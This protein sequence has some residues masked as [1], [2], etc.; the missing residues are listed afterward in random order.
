MSL[1][2]Y[3]KE[4]LSSEAEIE[5]MAG[6]LPP[7]LR[8]HPGAAGFVKL[9]HETTIRHRGDLRRRL[10]AGFAGEEER[11]DA[12]GTGSAGR[13]LG[14]LRALY[15]QVSQV[16]L[17]YAILHAV[18]HRYF[19]GPQEGTTAELAENH[20]K[21]YAEVVRLMNNAI[22]DVAVWELGRQGSECRCQ[23][24]ACGLGICLCS[25]HGTNTV[26]DV[27]RE[28]ASIPAARGTSGMGVR[29][30][31][32]GSPA[33]VAKIRSGDSVVSVDDQVI[34]DEG[35]E[36]IRKMQQKIDGH[37]PGDAIRLGVRRAKGGTDVISVPR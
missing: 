13:D 25:P 34:R 12:T 4:M 14:A 30:P 22:S 15:A 10:D 35:W 33:A 37:K 23:C 11:S 6:R 29:P 7:S 26:A 9:I 36:S 28:S 1:S 16:A 20:L 8:E 18:A 31:R 21:D 17:G 27:W 3:V 2:Q 24:P 32:R 19:D 5:E